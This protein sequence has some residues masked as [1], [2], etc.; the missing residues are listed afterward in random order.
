MKGTP[1]STLLLSLLKIYNVTS[2]A[3]SNV[4]ETPKRH[5]NPVVCHP[6]LHVDR[7]VEVISHGIN[8]SH[9]AV[10]KHTRYEDNIFL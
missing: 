5:I 2:S 8:K 7:F 4:K 10:L 9:V 3:N 1:N 6:I